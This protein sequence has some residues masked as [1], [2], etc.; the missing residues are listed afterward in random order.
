MPKD[1]TFESIAGSVRERLADNKPIRRTLP[2]YGRLH[3]DRQLPFLCVYRKPGGR[4]DTGTD[5]LVTGEASYLVA[6]TEP[7]LKGGVE[8]LTRAVVETL[9]G[10]FGAFLLVEIWT[11]E[12]ADS[13]ELDDDAFVPRPA[14]RI[15]AGRG[16]RAAGVVEDLAGWLRKIRYAKKPMLVVEAVGAKRNPP[17]MKA[18]LTKAVAD[19]LSC[20]HIGLEVKP[21]Y[22]DATTGEV[23]PAVLA[24][25]RRGLGR[26]LKQAFFEFARTQ[27][28]LR[29]AHYHALGRRAMAKAVWEVDARLAEI[30][31]SFD[32]LLQVTPVNAD[33]AWAAFKRNRFEKAPTLR[34]RPLPID[35]A[36]MK[37]A[38]YN[39]P[40]ERIEDP[41]VASLLG[42]RQ[43]ELDRELTMLQDRGTRRFL[44]G[45]LLLFGGVKQELLSQ[46]ERIIET[47][48]AAGPRDEPGRYV[49]TEE[50]ISRARAEIAHYAE[51]WDGFEA[52]V[53]VRDDVIS[54]LMV[55]R[56]NLLVARGY[57]AA[58][59]RVEPLLHHEIGTHLVTY[60]NG[61]AQRFRQLATGLAG[62]DALQEGLAVL[63]EYLSGG[64]S[65]PR[66]RLLAG[67]VIAAHLLIEGGTFVDAF[68]L[69]LRYGFEQRIA[70][71]VT[72]RVFRGGGLTKDVLYLRGLLEVLEYLKDGGAL[73]PLYVGKI[74]TAHI[75]LVRELQWRNVLAP[76]PL[77]PR[78]L[79]EP[80]SAERLARLREGVDV[81]ELV[82]RRGK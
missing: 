49:S 15:R 48:P 71:V 14:V 63:A 18:L 11:A 20:V 81:D 16:E 74:A 73:E 66:L 47:F 21:Y 76:A 54:G 56:G 46:A 80:R 42:E 37:R 40:I 25:F 50:F 19:E 4:D 9:A 59:S 17:G 6:S 5:R 3:I 33:K 55:S 62:Y 1:E 13:F 79:S 34:Y 41:A 10:V 27:T 8:R 52:G 24:S 67:R 60:Y 22:R 44:L 23:Y 61:R 38:L 77:Q 72:L 35:P 32:F 7:K 82:A 64:M 31:T 65:R 75:P 12:S 51:Q 78:Y 30:S 57:K 36:L 69:L 39:I 70:F 28:P 43:A 58:S 68:R 29:P 53:E 2:G 45:S 26:A